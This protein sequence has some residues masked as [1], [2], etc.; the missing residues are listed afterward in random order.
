MY[1]FLILSCV[2][3]SHVWTCPVSTIQQSPV[4]L[5]QHGQPRPDAQLNVLDHATANMPAKRERD[6]SSQPRSHHPGRLRQQLLLQSAEQSGPSPIR[7]GVVFDTRGFHNFYCHS[8]CQQSERF[9]SELCSVND[10][11]GEYRAVNG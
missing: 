2:R 6:R 9:L 10:K 1:L 3:C 11:H 4:Q 5:Q 8:V 7:S